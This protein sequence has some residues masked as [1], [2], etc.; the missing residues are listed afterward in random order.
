MKIGKEKSKTIFICSDMI[1]CIENCKEFPENI[2]E[3][4]YM[5]SQ[6]FQDTRSK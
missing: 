2:Y 4:K 1:L 5:S 3:N 6:R